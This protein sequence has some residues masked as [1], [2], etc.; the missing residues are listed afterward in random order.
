MNEDLHKYLWDILQAIKRLEKAAAP[1]IT[2]EQF[3]QN[4]IL[5]NAVERNF[6]IIGEALKR[7]LE[8]KPD[9][10]VTDARK[11]IGMRNIIAH[12]YDEVEAINLW[13]TIKKNIAI[14]KLEIESVLKEIS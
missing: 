3:S 11:I 8:I 10:R 7:A 4:D 6:E 12:N 1:P 2:L 9:L 13:G 14:L 5:I